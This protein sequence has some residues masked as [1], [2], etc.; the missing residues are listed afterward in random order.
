MRRLFTD[1]ERPL[2]GQAEPLE[3]APLPLDDV[4]VELSE[5][6]EELGED[7]VDALA[8]LVSAAAGHPQRTMLLAHLLHRELVPRAPRGRPRCPTAGR[9]RGHRARRRR[10]YDG[11]STRPTRRTRRSGTGCARARRR[12]SRRWPTAIRPTGRGDRASGLSSRATLQ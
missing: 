4:L 11:R 10:S 2:Y 8:P 9:G 5:R 6:F 1:R 7:P 12:C 3:L